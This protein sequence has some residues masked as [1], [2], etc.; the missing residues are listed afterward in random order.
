[1]LMFPQAVIPIVSMSLH[2]S[3]DPD[4]HIRVGQ[5]LAPLREQGVLILGSGASFHNFDYFFA[6]DS[7]TKREGVTHSHNFDQFLEETL[8][9]PLLP[10]SERLNRLRQWSTAPSARASHKVDQEEHLLPLHVVAGAGFGSAESSK[11][12]R[13]IGA[14]A[15]GSELAISSFEWPE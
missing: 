1:M 11:T 6:Q 7:K 2:R 15:S 3:F 9:S 12:A 14:P 5:A 13:R 10:S 8:T 4:Y